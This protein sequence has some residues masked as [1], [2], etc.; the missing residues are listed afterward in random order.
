MRGPVNTEECGFALLEQAKRDNSV[1]KE[2]E[3]LPY[4]ACRIKNKKEKKLIM[5]HAPTVSPEGCS[6]SPHA[7]T[8]DVSGTPVYQE[9]DRSSFC[10]TPNIEVA[11]NQ[12]AVDAPAEMSVEEL[13]E[14]LPPLQ[15]LDDTL[16]DYNNTLTYQP[17]PE[18]EDGSSTLFDFSYNNYGDELD[19]GYMS[20]PCSNFANFSSFDWG[21][22]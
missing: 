14:S 6:S 1:L 18:A 3:L 2:G 12:E 21:N 11:D 20:S 5:A 19:Y 13:M 17:H 22:V 8:S 15:P 9:G 16:L 10:D 7:C 4:V